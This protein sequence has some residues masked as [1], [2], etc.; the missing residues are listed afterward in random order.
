MTIARPSE[1]G[2]IL[3]TSNFSNTTGFAWKF[4]RRL[5][6]V[7]AREMHARGVGIR[8]SFAKIDGEVR[9]VDP[10]IPIGTTQFD[11]EH[12]TPAERRAFLRFV[13]AARVRYIYL[14]D[15]R[16]WSPLYPAMRMAG[17][18]TRRC[19]AR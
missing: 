14:T 2:S 12:H 5:Q 3:L 17:A 16:S 13:R 8:L 7:I 4:F 6:N 18:T 1:R 19:S 9:T 11:L 10:G 15:F